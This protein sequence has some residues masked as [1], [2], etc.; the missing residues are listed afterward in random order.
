MALEE[1]YVIGENLAV[2]VT[3]YD[4]A[5]K[6]HESLPYVYHIIYQSLVPNRLEIDV[7]GGD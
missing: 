6:H 1:M 2:C 5:A 4:D 7:S 3:C